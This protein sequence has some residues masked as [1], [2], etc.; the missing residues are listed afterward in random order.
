MGSTPLAATGRVIATGAACVDDGKMVFEPIRGLWLAG[1]APVSG[2]PRIGGCAVASSCA[3]AWRDNGLGD[4][5]G[6]STL[7]NVGNRR[8]KRETAY[9]WRYTSHYIPNEDEPSS[10]I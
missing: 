1:M 7:R 3:N 8:R 9:V 5:L 6:G 2:A 10:L 4:G